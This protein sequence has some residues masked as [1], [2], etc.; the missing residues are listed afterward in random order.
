MIRSSSWIAPEVAR[1]AAIASVAQE[2]LEFRLPGP[3]TA[4]R[5]LDWYDREARDLPWRVHARRHGSRRPSPY[6]V[7]LS[8]IMLQQT[9]VKA[10]IPYYL[11]FLER[12]PSVTK[13]AAAYLD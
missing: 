2:Q 9:T 4:Q 10:V 12:W 7:W 5:L 1:M 6:K 11:S 13:L 3:Q 8:E